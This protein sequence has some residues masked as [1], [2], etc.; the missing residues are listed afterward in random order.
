MMTYS[1]FFDEWRDG[2]DYVI[3]RTSGST[4]AP[5]QIK[6]PKE[7][8]RDSARRTIE[9]FN[10]NSRSHLHSCIS[11]DFIGGK[12]MAV[13]SEILG[14]GFSYEIPSNT[15]LVS[16]D[17]PDIDLLAVVPSQMVYILDNLSSLPKV[18][19]YLIGGSPIP[20]SIRRMIVGQ[21]LNAFESY[22]MTE[23]A[24][25]I[26]LRKVS[27]PSLP[28]RPLPGIEVCLDCNHRLMI[29]NKM[30]GENNFLLTNDI[31]EIDDDGQFF[32]IGRYDNVIISGGKKIHPEVLETTL[33][34]VLGIP[35]LF[36]AEKD[37][38]W[39]E[40]LILCINKS[41]DELSDE[42]LIDIC[43]L[44]LPDYCV[45]KKI[46][47]KEISVTANGKKRRKP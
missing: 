35:V 13:R 9:Y 21:G 28:F 5:K 26:A 20:D 16:Y 32:I 24:S 39:G 43:R 22:G 40:K 45:P 23:T 4:G 44:N 38:K 47:R 7:L 25:H 17:G 34:S 14:S 2:R 10:L 41:P 8:M 11:P 18:K 36:Y 15:P 42:R 30:F 12:M 1:Q 27:D 29:H 46:I 19:N 6:L 33:E 3:C 37:E 31:A